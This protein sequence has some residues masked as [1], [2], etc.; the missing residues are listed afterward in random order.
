M[1]MPTLYQIRAD[2]LQA[3]D[4]FTDPDEPDLPAEVIRDTLEGIEGALEL[5]AQ[6]VA[7]FVRSLETTAEAIK[8]AEQQMAQRRKTLER[9]AAS[10]RDYLKA[11][12]E[13][14]GISKIECPWFR[15]AIQKNPAAVDVTD[16]DQIPAEFVQIITTTKVDKVRLKAALKAGTEIPGARLSTGTRLVIK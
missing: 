13:A 6:N 15:L 5:K 16:E 10:L 1:T 11:N 7:A 4:Q 14:A 9:R 8:Q 12:M 2:Y 3:L